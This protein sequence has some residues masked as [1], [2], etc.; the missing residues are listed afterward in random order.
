MAR[1]LYFEDVRQQTG[2]LN[3]L[4]P[5][6]GPIEVV[7]IVGS[8]SSPRVAALRGDFRPRQGSATTSRYQSVC[9]AMQRGIPLPPIEVYALVGQY[10]V[11]DGHHRVAAAHA[12]GC[13]YLDAV[14]H[15]FLMP[16]IRADLDVRCPQPMDDVERREQLYLRLAVWLGAVCCTLWPPNLRTLRRGRGGSDP[17]A[18]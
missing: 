1:L 7:R 18:G 17:A 9:Q 14:V 2:A 3:R 11:V 4:P 15:E 13:F 5:H 16:D 8:V 10:F 12:L 6:L